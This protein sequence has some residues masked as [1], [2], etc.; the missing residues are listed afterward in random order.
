MIK[1]KS[2][3]SSKLT[4]GIIGIVI[5]AVAVGAILAVVWWNFVA[6]KGANNNVPYDIPPYDDTP[7]TINS[8]EECAAAGNP[9]LESYPEQCVAGGKTFVRDTRLDIQR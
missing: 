6:L 7:G 9:V 5:G 3:K 2:S 4:L 8:F 1:K